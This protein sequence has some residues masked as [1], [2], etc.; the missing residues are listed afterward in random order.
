MKFGRTRAI[1]LK[2]IMH[3]LR[4]PQVLIFA[5]G[6]PVVLLLLFGY[7]VSFDVEHI[8]LVLVD[9]DRTA[10]SRELAEAFTASGLFVSVGE[11]DDAD[12]AEL[13]LRQPNI[14]ALHAVTTTNALHYLYQT[15]GDPATHRALEAV[16]A[17][18][19]AVH[20]VAGQ[21]ITLPR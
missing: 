21:W 20:N 8:P 7:A 4:D 17:Q 12:A 9:Q 18:R 10:E 3:I 19:V 11:R 15:C 14:P 2:E 13:M 16:F 5:L 6:M 1:A